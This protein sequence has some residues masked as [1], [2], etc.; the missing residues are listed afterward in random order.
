MDDYM[1]FFRGMV[2]TVH[3]VHVSCA[4]KSGREAIFARRQQISCPIGWL[5]G[6]LCKMKV[7][8]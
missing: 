6:T 7:W 3:T 8:L 1:P 4:F 5:N 2:A